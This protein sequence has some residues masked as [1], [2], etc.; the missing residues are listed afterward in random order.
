MKCVC[1]TRDAGMIWEETY[2]AALQQIGFTAGRASPCC[3][4]HKDR[5]IHLVVHG[6]DLTAMGVRA[7]LDWYEERLGQSFELKI[8]GRIGEDT[9]LK[10]MRILNRIVTLTDEGLIYE[11][12]PRHAELMARNLALEEGKGVG[13]LESSLRTSLIRPSRRACSNHG[14]IRPGVTASPRATTRLIAAKIYN[15]RL[16]NKNVSAQHS[17]SFAIHML[18]NP[19]TWPQIV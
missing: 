17:R 2:G 16:Q 15:Q 8:R 11:S 1:G 18:T 19:R 6:D 9:T 10:T 5:S 7:D 14:T 12:D 4:F 3:F 13:H